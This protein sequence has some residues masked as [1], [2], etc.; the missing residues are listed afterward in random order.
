MRIYAT[1]DFSFNCI[2]MKMRDLLE[3]EDNI[4]NDELCHLANNILILMD[5]ELSKETKRYVSQ[6]YDLLNNRGFYDNVRV[7][8]EV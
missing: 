7:E 2:L 3:K 8:V 1:Q 4:R 6:V 5:T